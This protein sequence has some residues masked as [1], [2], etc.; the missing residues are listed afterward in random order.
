M[1]HTKRIAAL[2]MVVALL[3]AMSI[4][5]FAADTTGSITLDNP[6]DGKEYNASKSFDT[7]YND[8]KTNYAYTINKDSEWLSAVQ[9]FSNVTLTEAAGDPDVY[10]ATIKDGFSAADFA[11]H[12]KKYVDLAPAKNPIA[13][14][15]TPAT[16][17][18]LELGYYFVDNNNGALLNL[19]TTNPDVTIHDKNDVPFD[20]EVD[21]GTAEIGQILN[22]TITATVPDTTGFKNYLYKFHDEM[23][24][25]LTFLDDDEYSPVLTINGE[26]VDFKT[27]EGFTY[28]KNSDGFD[29]RIPVMNYQDVV[30]KE[31][32]FTY[33]AKVNEN[34][35]DKVQSNKATLK[36]SNNPDIDPDS[37][38]PDD[39]D[40]G[41]TTTPE[42]EEKTYTS[43]VTIAKYES[44]NKDKVLAGAKFVLKNSEGKYYKYADE[45][46]TW[47]DLAD[48]DVMIT[49][50]DGSALFK[51]LKDGDYELVET[52]APAGYNLLEKPVPVT[53]KGNNAS[54]ESLA[55]ISEVANSTGA[56][57]PSTGGVGTAIFYGA[58]ISLI[59]LAAVL[60]IIKRVTGKQDNNA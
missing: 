53:I 25:G 44:G 36:Y 24:S 47:V 18:G 43:K 41:T 38:D 6:A 7:V 8:G 19:T 10:V 5:V 12:L 58:G 26:N 32:V 20:K 16:A 31:I 35:L 33:Q 14:T 22:Y 11:N 42:D 56:M 15:G 13:L 27:V 1:K 4:H 59:L 54:D 51:G 34:A 46:V 45:A 21:A 9:A 23:T 48:A 50:T 49:E 60:F 52:E 2:M 40:D 39:P 37:V 17:T 3:F 30:G 55:V 29:L 57:L 28:T